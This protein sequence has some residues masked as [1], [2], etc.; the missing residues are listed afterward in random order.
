MSFSVITYKVTF[1]LT[2]FNEIFSR[3]NFF[4]SGYFRIPKERIKNLLIYQNDTEKTETID[5]LI[6]PLGGVRK[7]NYKIIH[8]IL[9]PGEAL[10]LDTE[11]MSVLLGGETEGSVFLC[12][13]GPSFKEAMTVKDLLLNWESSVGGSVFAVG[14]FPD[15]NIAA[16]KAKK[17][18]FMFCPLIFDKGSGVK[19]LNILL[20]H[21]SDPAYNDTIEITP[22]LNNLKGESI[23][24]NSVIIPP[25]GTGIIDV[26]VHFG[27]E[28]MALLARTGGYGGMTIQHVGHIFASYFFQANEHGDI[29][30]GNHTQPPIGIF[31]TSMTFRQLFKGEV[32]RMFPWVISLRKKIMDQKND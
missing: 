1:N 13:Q 8:K 3:S 27:K 24:G 2:M 28:G 5:A 29:I 31:G 22:H 6:F 12:L 20:N 11:E 26:E 25:F 14:P 30:C 15:L 23:V 19:N 18:F 21:S 10:V 7:N 16:T 32:K 17:S 9:A 4:F